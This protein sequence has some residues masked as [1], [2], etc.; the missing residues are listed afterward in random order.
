[1]PSLFFFRADADD[2]DGRRGPIGDDGLIDTIQAFPATRLVGAT[3]MGW[4]PPTQSPGSNPHLPASFLF[5][6]LFFIFS[7]IY[8]H[9]FFLS[10]LDP[11]LALSLGRRVCVLHS[12]A[13]ATDSLSPSHQQWTARG[14]QDNLLIDLAAYTRVYIHR[15]RRRRKRLFL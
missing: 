15:I 5:S 1:M 7:C 2:V 11:C 9:I 4:R 3:R 12:A 13:A 10:L 8:D 6:P 14:C